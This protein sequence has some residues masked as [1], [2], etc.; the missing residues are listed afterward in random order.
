M[1]IAHAY[2]KSVSPYSQGRFYQTE[3]LERESHADYEKR[4]WRDK[5]HTNEEENVFIPPMAL[6]NMLSSAA[7]YLGMQIPGKGKSTY[8]KY[9]ESGVMVIDPIVL[10]I[11]KNEVQGQWLFL[12]ADGKRGGS[13]RVEKCFPF[14]PKWEGEA[15]F[16]IIDDLITKS[17]FQKHLE[18]AGKFIGLGV[19]RPS[20]NGYYGRF[21]VVKLDWEKS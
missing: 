2:L 19:F 21:D 11:K 10:G 13:K 3:K 1:H 4:T 17:I 6:K 9:F 7:R 14:I 8:K 15:T 5:L 16:H 20:N 18:E 12:P